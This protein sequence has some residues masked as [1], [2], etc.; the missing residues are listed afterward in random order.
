MAGSQISTSVSIIDNLHGYQALS[1]TEYN[2]SATASICAGSVVEIAGAFFTFAGDEAIEASTWTSIVTGNTAYITLTASGTAG[3][4]I[5]VA[6]YTATATTWRDDLQGWYASA[7]SNVRVIGSVYKAEATNYA[8]KYT[9]ENKLSDH[10]YQIFTSSG[11]FLVPLNCSYVY[12]TGTAA[13]G[14]GGNG[15]SG[16]NS[17]GGGGGSGEKIYKKKI[18]V[19]PG[20]S[21]I[22]TI[23][24]PGSNTSF[25]SIS[26]NYG[27]NGV[28]ATSSVGGAGGAGGALLYGSEAGCSGGS[29][30]TTSVG[31]G[32][33]GYDTG[34]FAYAGNVASTSGGGGGGAGIGNFASYKVSTNGVSGVYTGGS[35]GR[36]GGGGGG[37]SYGN[38]TG[39]NGGVGGYGSGGGGGGGGL[40]TGGTGG[41]GGSAI[42]IVE[43]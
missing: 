33:N 17:A 28:N 3:S 40:T 19:S 29:G 27:V 42:L 15:Y 2:T 9:F 22:V 34:S 6:A 16:G 23:G 41:S 37:G 1:L 26:L 35:G 18:S 11:T 38:P 24:L 12:L 21:I 30:Y 8:N 36:N 14:N 32:T 7:A 43:W 31:V 25:G 20:T 39:G 13:G 10:G 4:Q 5:V